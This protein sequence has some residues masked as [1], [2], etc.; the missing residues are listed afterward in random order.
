MR[1]YNRKWQHVRQYNRKWL[2]VRQYDRKSLKTAQVFAAELLSDFREV[3]NIA[4]S[5]GNRQG[6]VY[7][8]YVQRMEGIKRDNHLETFKGDRDRE[9]ERERERQK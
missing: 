8:A 3:W 4:G 9:R 5:M 2:H 6:S 1:Q 7:I